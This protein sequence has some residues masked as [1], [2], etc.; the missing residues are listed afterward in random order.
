MNNQSARAPSSLEFILFNKRGNSGNN[1][2]DGNYREKFPTRNRNSQYRLRSFQIETPVSSPLV[3]CVRAIG[4]PQVEG[5]S[6][7]GMVSA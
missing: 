3:F 7:F 1:E 2:G 5:K 6:R 4:Q